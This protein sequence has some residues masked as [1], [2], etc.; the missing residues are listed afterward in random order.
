VRQLRGQGAAAAAARVLCSASG[1]GGVACLAAIAAGVALGLLVAPQCFFIVAV[2]YVLHIKVSCAS[3]SAGLVGNVV[4]GAGALADSFEAAYRANATFR[5]RIECY[6]Y[7]TRTVHGK[8]GHSHKKRVR[9]TTYV[10]TRTGRLRTFDVS[11]PFVPAAD[12]CALTQLHARA[13]VRVLFDDYF[14]ERDAWRA[15]N[16]RDAHQDFSAVETI[17]EMQPETLVEF[18]PGS[19]PWWVSRA[20]FALATLALSSLCFRVAFAAKCGEHQYA[21]FKDAI[22]FTEDEISEEARA[23]DAETAAAAVAFP[24][25]PTGGPPLVAPVACV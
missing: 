5:W 23:L 13:H 11:P 10:A 22:G 12:A 3:D 7:E 2:A 14:V 24:F 21:F 20:V 15:A 17:A 18:V 1:L 25:A 6:H 4:T 8:K 16:R 19:R 9:V